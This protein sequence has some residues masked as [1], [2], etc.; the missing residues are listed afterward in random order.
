MAAAAQSN[1][2]RTVPSVPRSSLWTILAHTTWLGRGRRARGDC[3]TEVPRDLI[4]HP[5]LYEWR[6]TIHRL[7]A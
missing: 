4:A 2:F 6:P 5:S 3:I 1:L 7:T